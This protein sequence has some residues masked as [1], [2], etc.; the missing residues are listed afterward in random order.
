[1]FFSGVVNISDLRGEHKL[2][3]RGA[4]FVAGLSSIAFSIA[5]ITRAGLGAPPSSS[6]SVTMSTI[7]PITMG[8]FE[9]VLNLM[10]VMAQVA[11][12]NKRFRPFLLVQLPLAFAL[13]SGVDISLRVLDG[14][15]FGSYAAQ[16][17]GLLVGCILNGSGIAM[18]VAAHFVALPGDNLVAVIS[19]TYHLDFGAVKVG[20]DVFFLVL[21]STIGLAVL[22]HVTGIRE[23]TFVVA[24]TVGPI[25]RF[26]R[27]KL[28]HALYGGMP[29][30]R[31]R[32]AD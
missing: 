14:F 15:V 10:Y 23:G 21:T 5:L 31:D 11:I 20:Y 9:I 6:L 3:Y 27:L 2:V 29:G 4:L 32:A 8:Q 28:E 1:M 24:L 16:V 13:G 12:L 17:A 30:S 7:L 25:A 22:G 19:D 26:V 18:C